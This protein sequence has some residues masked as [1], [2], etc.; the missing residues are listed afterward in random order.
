M[1]NI[2]RAVQEEIVDMK[3]NYKKAWTTKIVT[4]KINWQHL[5]LI[6]V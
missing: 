1:N 5:N 2:K 6:Q 4:T 3:Y